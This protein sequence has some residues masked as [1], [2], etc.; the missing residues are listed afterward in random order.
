MDGGAPPPSLSL[1]LTIEPVQVSVEARHRGD[2]L[3]KRWLGI[4][5]LLARPGDACSYE[6]RSRYG[7]LTCSWLIDT[8]RSYG[9]AL[10]ERVLALPVVATQFDITFEFAMVAAPDGGEVNDQLADRGSDAGAS[11]SPASDVPAHEL[12]TNRAFMGGMLDLDYAI[13]H[14]GPPDER[15]N[16]YDN[17]PETVDEAAELRRAQGLISCTE[18]WLVGDFGH[19]AVAARNATPAPF[20]P[21]HLRARSEAIQATVAGPPPLDAAKHFAS[22]SA[23]KLAEAAELGIETEAGQDCALEAAHYAGACV[24]VAAHAHGQRPHAYVRALG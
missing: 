6:S 4:D 12:R 21:E 8:G 5:S 3:W 17:L 10:A 9:H 16:V 22:M 18:G 13:D 23:L 11:A 14:G 24:A 7:W 15:L 20:D 19:E 1:E 2:P